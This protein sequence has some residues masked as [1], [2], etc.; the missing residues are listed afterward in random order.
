MQGQMIISYILEQET[1]TPLVTG[2]AF[3]SA[4]AAMPVNKN[5]VLKLH[6][7]YVKQK[8]MF[9]ALPPP[10]VQE[11]ARDKR[12]D[13]PNT[14][15]ETFHLGATDMEIKFPV[16]PKQT[17][18][19]ST[20]DLHQHVS[21]TLTEDANGYL[22]TYFTSVIQSDRVSTIDSAAFYRAIAT[23]NT[24]LRQTYKFEIAKEENIDFKGCKARSTRG[25][26]QTEDDSNYKYYGLTLTRKNYIISMYVLTSHNYL[27][28]DKRIPYF[29]NSL[30]WDRQVRE[31]DAH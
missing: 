5:Q 28:W 14:A 2:I 19:Q 6:A 9:D 16:E 26:I 29:F 15:W 23:F 20:K 17:N 22:L 3:K 1:N 21:K 4:S 10:P 24:Y 27:D 12:K 25:N 30:Q 31:K 18:T 7:E 13:K 11:E 8:K